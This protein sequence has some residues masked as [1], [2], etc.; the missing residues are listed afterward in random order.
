V[1][2]K[3]KRIMGSLVVELA[4]SVLVADVLAWENIL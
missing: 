4:K 3:K 1:K 2:K